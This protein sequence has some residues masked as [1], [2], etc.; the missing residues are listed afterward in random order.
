M[1]R[2]PLFACQTCIMDLHVSGVTLACQLS[3][4][5]LSV[6]PFPDRYRTL[7]YGN[8][9]TITL[10]DTCQIQEATHAAQSSCRWQASM[11]I[12]Q[13]I[14]AMSYTS[15]HMRPNQKLRCTGLEDSSLS[16]RL[17]QG[18]P[19]YFKEDDKLYHSANGELRR[20]QTLQGTLRQDI[21][22]SALD[23]LVRVPVLALGHAL[24]LDMTLHIKSLMYAPSPFVY[25]SVVFY[26]S[27]LQ[28][29]C[30]PSF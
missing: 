30:H 19:S 14:H 8:M 10:M 12:S 23:K 3:H 28:A 9:S 5:H 20:A 18:C 24:M 27:T 1:S 29:N 11:Y 4:A 16:S 6:W 17:Q 21:T 13:T 7:L 2:S 22:R 26:G 25:I 15:R